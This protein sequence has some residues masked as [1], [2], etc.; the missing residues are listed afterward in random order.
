MIK[1]RRS[2]QRSG[3]NFLQIVMFVLFLLLLFFFVLAPLFFQISHESKVLA[4]FISALVRMRRFFQVLSPRKTRTA[5]CSR[6]VT[7]TGASHS[8]N[9]DTIFAL[10]S[11]SEGVSGVAI[12][13]ISGPNARHCLESLTKKTAT[14]PQP[15]MASLRHLVS[16]T[17]QEVLDHAMVS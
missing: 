11:G 4:L 12:I 6:L 15:R 16:P 1:A 7:T 17:T 3:V 14:F 9:N 8:N 2:Q 5:I 10:S 13:R